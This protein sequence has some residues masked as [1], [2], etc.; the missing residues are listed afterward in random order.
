M[1]QPLSQPKIW[2]NK[3]ERESFID[4]LGSGYDGWGFIMFQ[5]MMK[6]DDE[7]GTDEMFDVE[8]DWKLIF[9]E[10]PFANTE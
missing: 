9:K 1:E 3:D 2:W 7:L 6:S 5:W 8:M 4:E 10:W